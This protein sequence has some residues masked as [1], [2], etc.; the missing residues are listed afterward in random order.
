MGAGVVFSIRLP[1]FNVPPALL[2]KV[3]AVSYDDILNILKLRLKELETNLC[4]FSMSA[5]EHKYYFFYIQN[6]LLDIVCNV[7]KMVG[8]GLYK[9]SLPCCCSFFLGHLP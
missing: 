1:N 7:K 9:H 5:A 2:N 6:I 3:V 4:Y 8:V